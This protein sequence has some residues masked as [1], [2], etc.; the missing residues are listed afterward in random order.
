MGGHCRAIHIARLFYGKDGIM[1]Q[2]LRILCSWWTEWLVSM[3]NDVDAAKRKLSIDEQE[4]RDR[5]RRDQYHKWLN[6]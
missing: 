2:D 5:N 4:D 3:F 1:M 6:S